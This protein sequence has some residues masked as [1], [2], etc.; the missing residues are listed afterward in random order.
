VPDA[1]IRARAAELTRQ[2]TTEAEK[3]RAIASFVRGIR[4]QTT[5]F[6]MSAYIPTAGKQ[7][8]RERYGDCKD[9]AALL[10][11]LLKAVDIHANMVLLNLRAQ[12]IT[13]FL[14]STRFEHA[15]AVV[16]TTGSPMWIDATADDLAIGD[17]PCLDQDVPALVIDDA[18][19]DLS[20]TPVLPIELNA[21]HESVDAT[22]D[23]DGKLS[24]SVNI[25]FKGNTAWLLRTYLKQVPEAKRELVP[26]GMAIE[27]ARN[28]VYES[29][30]IDNF[31]NPD[32]PFV[33]RLAFHADN[34]GT[35]AGNFLLLKLPWYLG[36][37]SGETAV[38]YP[39]RTQDLEL[40]PARSMVVC[41]V[42]L[43]LPHGYSV[44]DLQPEAGGG[45]AYGRYR[46]TYR[47]DGDLLHADFEAQF[48]AMR[49]PRA[50]LKQYID[51]DRGTTQ[52]AGKQLV[53]KRS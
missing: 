13:P 15:I 45:S 46:A 16:R 23:E 25:T 20:K 2:A 40:G 24:A 21:T 47:M 39:S 6:R 28:A 14:P 29:G 22:L 7:V 44:Q 27:L 50:D 36:K 48:P 5:P 11:A 19:T 30:A 49:V 32:L 4:Y 42:R 18:T 33:I 34:Y 35:K 41:T 1:V 9:K 43:R 10:T 17:L 3:V 53:L 8:L 12:G 51:F 37:G 26:K 31:D 38:D 52:E